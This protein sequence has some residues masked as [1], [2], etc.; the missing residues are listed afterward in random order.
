MELAG[1]FQASA[2]TR[3][4]VTHLALTEIL[5]E[6]QRMRTEPI[7]NEELELQRQYNVGNYLLSLESAART[8]QRVQDIDLYGLPTDYYKHYAKEMAAVTPPLAQDLA[9]KYFDSENSMVVI[10]GE[11]KDVRP[12][13]EKL[14]KVT[15][16]DTELKAA[17]A[18]E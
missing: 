15:V 1:A 4:E 18:T 9:K 11:A 3:N 6:M 16:Y 13:L 17:A 5:K 7:P 12:E 14:G 2:E 8:A 10:V